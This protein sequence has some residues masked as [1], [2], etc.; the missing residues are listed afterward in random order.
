MDEPRTQSASER[1]VAAAGPDD[2]SLSVDA[3]VVVAHS[4]QSDPEPLA[5]FA[6]RLAGD[7]VDELARSTDARWRFV[8][9]EPDRLSDGTARQPAEFLDVAAERMVD[10]PYDLVVVVTDVPLLARDQT[11][12]PGLASPVSRVAV[13]STDRLRSGPRDRPVRALDDPAV[14]WNGAALLAHLLGHVLGATHGDGEAMQPFRFDS[15]RRSVPS[16]D[17]YAQ[18]YLESVAS[19]IPESETAE[20]GPLARLTFHLRSAL[21]NPRQVGRALADSRGLLLPLSLPKLSTAAVTPTLILVF[22]AETWDV[23]LNLTNGTAAAFAIAAVLAAATHVMFVQ[24]LFFPRRHSQVTTEHMALVNVT[25]YLILLLG[26]VGLF[27]LVGAIMLVIEFYVFPPNLMTNWP[28]LTNP[29]IDLVDL[30]RT[31]GFIATI[32]VLS[33]ALAGGLENRTLVRHLAL[34]RDEP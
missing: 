13:I 16:F 23:G 6:E 22:S 3:G 33:G 29:E 28:S 15:D 20:R 25:A 4:P 14:R 34:F 17:A 11:R 8:R 18:H 12:V 26:T 1:P 21:A 32:G 31:G 24:N 9:D 27:L 5:A 10:G 2:A 30:L 19:S 7:V